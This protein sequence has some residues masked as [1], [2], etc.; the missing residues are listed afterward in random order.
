MYMF[1]GCK[2]IEVVVGVLVQLDGQ[3]LLVQCL[4]GKFYVGYWEFFGGKFEVGELVE[5]VFMCE[6]KEELDVM[7]CVCVF[8]YIIEYD[9]LYVYVCLY[10]CKVMVW[11]GILCVLEGQDFVWQMLLISV[12][13]VLL[14][15]LFVFEW[16]CEEVMVS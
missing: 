4:E 2:I 15:M 10:F 8:W 14:V 9:Y 5:V 12:D 3:F 11:D 13:L 16:M 6:L 7:L 1:D